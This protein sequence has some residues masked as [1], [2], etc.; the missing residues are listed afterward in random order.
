LWVK[1]IQN[2]IL[3]FWKYVYILFTALLSSIF[4]IL[5]NLNI[6]KNKKISLCLYILWNLIL[7]FFLLINFNLLRDLY[8]LNNNFTELTN[9]FN[10]KVNNTLKF[11]TYL[12]LNHIFI[13]RDFKYIYE[14]NTYECRLTLSYYDKNSKKKLSKINMYVWLRDNTQCRNIF[15]K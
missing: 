8:N 6:I 3:P 1:Q 15:E 7:V 4:I 9:D 2:I 10:T 5:Y 12:K 11:T 14:W 13:S